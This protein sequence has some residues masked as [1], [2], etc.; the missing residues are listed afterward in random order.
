MTAAPAISMSSFG[1]AKNGGTDRDWEDAAAHSER[2][3]RFAVADG[4]SS[5][6]RAEL[7]S[8]LLVSGFL[9]EPFPLDDGPAFY[10]WVDRQAMLWNEG[11]A[12]DESAP[13]YARLAQARGSHS[14]F[15]GV[16]F[17]PDET[18]RAIAVG[19]TCLFVVRDGVVTEAFPL[20]R[21]ED[22][23]FHPELVGTQGTPGEVRLCRGRL[24]EGDVV[25]AAT[26][27]MAE[28]LLRAHVAASEEPLAAIL[29]ALD[30]IDD[31]VAAGRRSGH[32]RND[33][34]TVVRCLIGGAS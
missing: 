16:E 20:N 1:V 15:L 29:G 18:Y 8:Q 31:L 24:Q 33:D 13:Y 7:W 23:G 32:L 12:V 4:T 22:F 5:A 14:T 11:T 27:A 28:W 34:V 9:A 10:A 25:I 6:Y 26:D 19:D 30:S 17:G 3:R 2:A 21:A